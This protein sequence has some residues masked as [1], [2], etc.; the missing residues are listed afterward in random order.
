MDRNGR[1][2]HYVH[3]AMLYQAIPQRQEWVIGCVVIPS[4]WRVVLAICSVAIVIGPATVRV[5]EDTY[6][7][8]QIDPLE[9]KCYILVFRSLHPLPD[10]KINKFGLCVLSSTGIA[11]AHPSRTYYGESSNAIEY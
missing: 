11:S 9:V 7:G 6:A 4:E 5:G 10:Q 8:M 2:P 1:V 3:D